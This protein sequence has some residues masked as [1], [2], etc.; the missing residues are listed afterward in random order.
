[1]RNLKILLSCLCPFKTEQEDLKPKFN[2]AYFTRN[3][4]IL[5]IP[6]ND[7]FF[8]ENTEDYYLGKGKFGEVYK[9]TSTTE[10]NKCSAIK[11]F[12][13]NKNLSK[14]AFTNEVLCL[15]KLKRNENLI[16]MFSFFSAF[17]DTGQKYCLE[18]EYC[19]EKTLA[20][21]Y[22]HKEAKLYTEEDVRSIIFQITSGLNF[23]LSKNVVHRD[24]KPS[25][26]LVRAYK[27][28]ID[29]VICDIN[30][31][32]DF[33]LDPFGHEHAELQTSAGTH[34]YVAPEII[35]KKIRRDG[36]YNF[37]CDVWSLGIVTYEL[38]A[39]NQK[40]FAIP[41]K[42]KLEIENRKDQSDRQKMV[43]I[44]KYSFRKADRYGVDF[45]PPE[46]WV[47]ISLEAQTLLL[48]MLTPRPYNSRPSYDE[49]LQSA[50]MNI[51]FADRPLKPLYEP[52]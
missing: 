13:F 34:F 22:Y 10:A 37:K 38:L 36:K 21:I 19:P 12:D 7:V 35:V 5:T 3:N 28:E 45:T 30:L 44:Q 43:S 15:L 26:I 18:L 16:Q 1:M 40:P 14:E 17:V 9:Y 39:G 41:E 31:S 4:R 48:K 33:S 51:D 47:D 29:V 11:F 8:R 50:W 27:P 32:K 46:K 6:K 20:D 25:N 2:M 24:I 42:E 52:V 49:I 23:M